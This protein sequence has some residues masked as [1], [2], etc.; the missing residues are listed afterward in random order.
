MSWRGSA[1]GIK[2]AQLGHDVIM[3][4]NDYCY[5]DYYQSEDTRHEPLHR[6]ALSHWRSIQSESYRLTDRRTSQAHTRHTSQPL[7]RIHPDQRTGRVYGSPPYGRPCRSTMDTTGK[8]RLYKLH[9]PTGRTHRLYR[10][11][12]LNYREPFR[13]QADST[14]T[15]KK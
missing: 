8:E 3:T 7:D 10:R 5:F 12:G 6:E 11:D 14:A 15:E 1:G 9:Y 13:Q 2:A 4:P